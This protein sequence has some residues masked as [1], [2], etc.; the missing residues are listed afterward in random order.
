VEYHIVTNLSENHMEQ[1]KK[2]F[3]AEWWTKGR[4]LSDI[5]IMLENS[6]III[7]CCD[8]T[9]NELIGFTRVLTDFV[10]KAF[11]FDVIVKESYRGQDLGRVLIETVLENPSLQ[12]VKHFE[13]YCRPEMVSY[14]KKW[15]FSEEL[16]ELTFMRKV[17]K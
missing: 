13:L 12:K 4:E 8:P 11:I 7:G 16:G 9:N 2:L 15:G 14:Y 5:K 1:L 10:Y 6:D 3:Q 17:K